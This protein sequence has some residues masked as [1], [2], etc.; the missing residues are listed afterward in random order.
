MYKISNP[1]RENMKEVTQ[2]THDPFQELGK[3]G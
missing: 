1:R 2:T 3:E